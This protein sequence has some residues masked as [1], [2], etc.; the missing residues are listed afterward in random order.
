MHSNYDMSRPITKTKHMPKPRVTNYALILL[1]V[2]QIDSNH[3]K[4]DGYTKKELVIDALGHLNT[5]FQNW[6]MSDAA[7]CAE[8]A[9]FNH[10]DLLVFNR[11]TNRWYPGGNFYRYFNYHFGPYGMV[12]LDRNSAYDDAIEVNMHS[13]IARDRVRTEY[14][15]MKKIQEAGRDYFFQ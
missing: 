14:Q 9:A 3:P 8:F 4:I 1:K 10:N 6:Q 15:K 5:K 11:K 7:F 12:P 13:D 2:V